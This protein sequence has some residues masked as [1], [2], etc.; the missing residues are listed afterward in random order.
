MQNPLSLKRGRSKS[1]G[2]NVCQNRSRG[3]SKTRKKSGK[4]FHH[5]KEG[6]KKYF[7]AWKKEQK[8]SSNKK[9]DNTKNTTVALNHEVM[10]FANEDEECFECHR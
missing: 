4:C 10:I 9:K 7:F 3:K 1:R 5:G 8:E 2:P 6:H